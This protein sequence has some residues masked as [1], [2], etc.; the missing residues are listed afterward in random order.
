MFSASPSVARGQTATITGGADASGKTYTWQ[1]A[2][3][4]ASRMV[5]ARFPHYRATLF[6]PP[7]GWSSDCTGLV[8]P[9]FKEES[10]VCS[11]RATDPGDGIAPGRSASFSM[12][13]T[14]AGTK[15][16]PAEAV[17]RFADGSESV[18]KG[19][20]LPLREGIGDK[21]VSLIALGAAFIIF[22]AVRTLR[23]R[24]TETS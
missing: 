18:V 6:F 3:T 1:I 23:K 7:V 5:E 20:E 12:Q 2:N 10:G 13:V 8:R 14:A 16:G 11:A 24:R 4:G 21:Y 19:V 17:I 15:R 9:G 22:V